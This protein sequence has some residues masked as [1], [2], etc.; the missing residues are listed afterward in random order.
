M[1]RSLGLLEG[2]KVRKM[3]VHLFA[4]N[5]PPF[6]RSATRFKITAQTGFREA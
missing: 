2:H 4:S 3:V 6:E 1:K 5:D